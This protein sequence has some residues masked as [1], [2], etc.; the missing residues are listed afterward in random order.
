M[1][2]RCFPL[3]AH[4]YFSSESNINIF[5]S[6][7]PGLHRLLL[8]TAPRNNGRSRLSLTVTSYSTRFVSCHRNS[9]TWP[10]VRNPSCTKVSVAEPRNGSTCTDSCIWAPC[11]PHN[12]LHFLKKN[13]D[14]FQLLL[15][16]NTEHSTH[17]RPVNYHSREYERRLS[18]FMYVMANRTLRIPWMQSQGHHLR[19][20]QLASTSRD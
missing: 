8:F 14:F 9:F 3:W 20:T 17:V 7:L 2:I 11:F 15:F 4:D 10:T 5:Y 12:R 13:V 6:S 1:P 16:Y 19:E 18:V